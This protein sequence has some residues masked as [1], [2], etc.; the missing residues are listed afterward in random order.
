VIPIDASAASLR[1]LDLAIDQAAVFG[2][3]SLVLVNVQNV[4]TLGLVEGAAIMPPG[5][6]EQEEEQA[7]SAAL[8]KAIDICRTAGVPYRVRSERGAVAETI[9]RVAREEKAVHI[10]MGTTGLSE[11]RGLLLGS[12]TTQLLHLTDIPVTLVR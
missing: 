3:A 7:A 8:E 4:A 6:I 2:A 9:N 12:V 11:M 1:A 10:I 5:W